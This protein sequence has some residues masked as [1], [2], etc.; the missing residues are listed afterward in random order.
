MKEKTGSDFKNWAT[1]YIMLHTKYKSYI[2][3]L[4]QAYYLCFI[5]NFMPMVA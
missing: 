2:T 1:M 4:I 5:Q 3:P